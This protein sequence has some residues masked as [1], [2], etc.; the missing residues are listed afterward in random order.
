MTIGVLAVQG[1]FIEHEHMLEKLGIPKHT[2]HATRHTYA[3]W[4][5]NA[6][7]QQEILQKIIGHAS[8]ST[9]ADIYIHADAEK[10]ISAVES[11][12]NL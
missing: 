10:L 9:T 7:I 12:S 2:P 1:A 11:A 5:R 4:A 8:F 6:G 3:T